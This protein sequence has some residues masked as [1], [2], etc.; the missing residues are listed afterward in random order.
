M[1]FSCEEGLIHYDL[2]MPV[3]MPESSK[4]FIRTVSCKYE[5]DSLIYAGGFAAQPSSDPVPSMDHSYNNI[6]FD[7]AAPFYDSP[8]QIKYSYMLEGYDENWSGWQANSLKEYT[9]LREGKYTFYVK[10]RNVCGKESEATSFV[11]IVKPPWFR[12]FY[13]Y[14][15]YFFLSLAISMLIF[16]LYKLRVIQ[17]RVVLEKKQQD[18]LMKQEQLFNAENL[19]NEKKLIQLEREKLVANMEHKNKELAN[20]T[21]NLIRK[22]EV[23]MELKENISK[24]MALVKEKIVIDKLKTVVA[25]IDKNIETDNDWDTFETHFDAVHENFLKTLKKKYPM[26]SPKDMKLCAYLRMNLSTKEIAPLLNISPRGVEISRYRLRKKLSID[27][28]CN[29][30]EFMMEI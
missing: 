15:F 12:T 3:K 2:T 19:E 22:N 4:C 30:T 24:L 26:L 10:A 13:A 28:E 1:F 5:A 9:N 6:R 21:M 8:G 20:S 27:R 29:L 7:Y 25:H 14:V 23:L 16:R 17:E 18:E 11:F